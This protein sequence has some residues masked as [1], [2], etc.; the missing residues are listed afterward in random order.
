MK[1]QKTLKSL[2]FSLFFFLVFPFI[3]FSQSIIGDWHGMIDMQG[4]K[5]SLTL[6]IMQD[7]NGY[8]ATLD[9]PD[10]NAFKIPLDTLTLESNQVKFTFSQ[11]GA[12]YTGSVNKSFTLI[13]GTFSQNGQDIP[14]KMQREKI[15]PTEGS[16]AYV[17]EKY[18]KREVYIPMRDGV[19]LFT[20]I[21]TPR[22]STQNYPILMFRT[23][24]NASPS[25]KGYTFFL[26]L[27]PNYVKEG[28][29]FVFQ[30]V[31]GRYM[32]EGEFEDVRPYIPN[33]KTKNDI[34]ESSD[35]YDSMDWLVK[36]VPR[37]NGNIGIT[38]TSYPGFYATMS[39][40]DAHPALKAVSPQAP[41]TDWF[42]GDD[43]HHNGAF[44]MLDAFSFYYSFGRPHPEPTRKSEP[45]FKWPVDDS[46]EFFMRVG[47]DKNIVERYFGD[48]LHFWNDAT[49]HPNYDDFWKART[50]LPHLKNVN[51]AVLTVGGL[52]DA[53]DLYGPLHVYGSIEKQNSPS[54]SNR[55]VMGPWSHGQWNGYKAENLGNIYWG[56]DA[57][58]HFKEVEFNFFNYY[59]K[60]KGEMDL[61]EATIFITG[62]N[63][64]HD[65][66]TWPPENV[67]EKELY[68]QPH[69]ELSFSAPVATKSFDEYV[70]DPMKPVPYTEDVHLRRTREYMTDDQRFAARRPDVMVYQTGELSEDITFTG[71]LKAD[72]FVST[73][74]T[75]ADYVVKL[76]DVFPDKMPNY[77]KNEKRVPMGGYQMLVRGEVMR[78]RFRNSFENPV[79]F[80]P[81]KVTEVK[82]ILQDVAHT[83]KKG[84]HIMVQVQNS[85][86][87]L[88]DRNPQKFV[89]IYHCSQDDFQKATQRIYHDK[90]YPSHIEVRVFPKEP[91]QE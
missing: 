34:D 59:L 14:L 51:P 64:W 33:K 8:K 3:S 1:T 50:P 89:D 31:R 46:Y 29:I 52:F 85:W 9:S 81:G 47:P 61:P 55:L 53:E 32:S 76:I 70:S 80:K 71:P 44:F 49:S 42:I 90:K 23:P 30:D 87:P 74:G 73:T 66:E 26:L 16:M 78:G 12:S 5:L 15:K 56:F 67:I 86:F 58:K 82:F 38:G 54:V 45:G 18:K 69:G 75:D 43:F 22:D 13:T 7:Q 77:H 24:Y 72:L 4:I 83:F 20:A 40:P 27:Y 6:H 39:I 21:Y 37:N 10:Q 25:E 19:K 68:F 17:K 2:S 63:E 28:Y 57:N 41:V 62:R 91:T 65:F 84:H 36:N 79:P 48:T 11:A 60:G 35:T 88:V